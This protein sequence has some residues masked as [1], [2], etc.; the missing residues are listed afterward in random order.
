[1]GDLGE[2]EL[3]RLLGDEAPA[4]EVGRRWSSGPARRLDATPLAATRNAQH[5]RLAHEPGDPFLAHADALGA[6]T[7]DVASRRSTRRG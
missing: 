5:A 6:Q 2:P 7:V 3:V 1:V 4:D